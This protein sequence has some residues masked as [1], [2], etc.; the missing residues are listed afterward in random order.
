[1]RGYYRDTLG[2]GDM[3]CFYVLHVG[4]R[5]SLT[6]SLT[7]DYCFDSSAFNPLLTVSAETLHSDTPHLNMS[8]SS[9]SSLQLWGALSSRETWL[10]VWTALSLSERRNVS[11]RHRRVLLSCR[12]GGMTTC[13]PS[14]AKPADVHVSANGE[15]LNPKLRSAR[16]C[17]ELRLNVSTTVLYCSVSS[18]KFSSHQAEEDSLIKGH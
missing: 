14:T 4:F 8:P 16:L 2:N 3:C 6:P 11:S 18:S 15:F 10:P 12:L 7:S 13:T 1:M 5:H 9:V 17:S